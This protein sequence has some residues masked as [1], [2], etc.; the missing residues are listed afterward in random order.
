MA[1]ANRYTGS[2]MALTINDIPLAAD[3][4]SL[5]VK[6]SVNSAE[7]TAGGDAHEYSVPTYAAS[8]ISVELLGVAQDDDEYGDIQTET[9][10]GATGDLVWGPEGDAEGAPRFTA[11]GY[12]ESRDQDLKFD[13]M[14]TLK[15]TYKCTA[16]IVEDTYPAP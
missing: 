2:A 1:L 14:V 16:D 5:A 4:K 6:E 9:A 8:S 7:G 15:F 13:D 10:K 3:Y 12:V 11:T